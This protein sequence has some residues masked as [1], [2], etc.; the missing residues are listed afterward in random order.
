MAQKRNVYKGGP[1][2]RDYDL[3]G[4]EL[5]FYWITPQLAKATAIDDKTL[6]AEYSRLRAIANK[7]LARMEGKPEAVGTLAR[8]PEPF[9]T[10]RGMDR[11]EVV[12]QLGEVSSFLTARRGS[13]SGIKES[14]KEIRKALAKKGVEVPQDQLNKFGAFMNAMKKALGIKRGDYASSQLASLWQ[15]LFSEGKISQASFERKIK[16]LMAEQAEEKGKPIS[17]E[18]RQK[19]NRLLREAPINTFF[20]EL[21]LDPRTVKA[22]ERRQEKE[23]ELA[24]QA[25][26]RAQVA[27]RR[28]RG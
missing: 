24:R 12:R 17:R 19:I 21:A 13:L 20:D 5:Q 3:F 2:A 18:D 22:K 26:R 14:N 28:G 4:P 7:R 9:P 15:E 27:R 6:R 25:R 11:A 10:V 23:A 1:K 8:H 16:D